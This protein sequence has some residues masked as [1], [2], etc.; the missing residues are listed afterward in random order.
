MLLEGMGGTRWK[1]LQH[2]R[3][4][5]DRKDSSGMVI[6]P[7]DYISMVF[8]EGN[9]YKSTAAAGRIDVHCER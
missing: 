6:P 7:I 2:P 8:L 9:N 1:V 4:A 3:S 5:T